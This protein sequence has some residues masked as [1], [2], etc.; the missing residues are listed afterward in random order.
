MSDDRSRAATVAAEALAA[1]REPDWR[2]LLETSRGEDRELLNEL[3][4]ISSIAAFHDRL[5]HSAEPVA[6]TAAAADEGESLGTWGPL[7]LREEIGRG[8]FGSVYRAWDPRIER[9]VALK[10]I[11]SHDAAVQHASL[12]IEEGRKLAR[13]RHPNV[14]TIF[15]AASVGGRTGLE[16]ELVEGIRLDDLVR[17]RGP[18][19]AEEAA[20]IGR[21]VCRGLAAIHRAGLVHR[22]V[23]AQNVMRESGGRIVLMD[24][25]ASAHGAS[26]Q[27]ATTVQGVTGTPMYAALE[28]LNGERASP[29]TDFYSLG[30]LL[31]FLVSGTYPFAA[32]QLA[33][34]RIAHANRARRRLREL[35]PD[36]P[37]GFVNVV[38]RATSSD[39][40]QR[41]QTAADFELALTAT[42]E[43]PGPVP[44]PASGGARARM[45]F[46]AT[47]LGIAA[48]LLV[49]WIA[50]TSD[51][52][53]AE[54]VERFSIDLPEELTPPTAPGSAPLAISPDGS[55]LAYA[56]LVRRVGSQIY[57]RPVGS[58]RSTLVEGTGDSGQPF[59][60]P[61]ARFVGYHRTFAP[62]GRMMISPTGP[63]AAPT[64][65]TEWPRPAGATWLNDGNIVYSSSGDLWKI[66][67]TGGTPE[68]LT[69]V[70]VNAGEMAIRPHGLPG[71]EILFTLRGRSDQH[72]VALLT[73][74]GVITPLVDGRNA[75]HIAPDVLL[76][77]RGNMMMAA[78]LDLARRRLAG[79]E[80]Q[81]SVTSSEWFTAS[82]TGVVIEATPGNLPPSQPPPRLVWVDRTTGAETPLGLPN[83]ENFLPGSLILSPDG[84]RLAVVVR[85]SIGAAVDGDEA[86]RVWIA[87]L[88]RRTVQPLTEAAARV[89]GWTRD[90]REVFYVNDRGQLA[91]R[92]G[93]GG[94]PERVVG[95]PGHGPFDGCRRS[96]PTPDG[97]ALVLSCAGR[98][99]VLPLE[100]T[101]G[102]ATGR[103]QPWRDNNGFNEGAPLL[104]PD[105]R[106]LFFQ[107]NRDGRQNLFV[108]P[109]QGGGPSI[110]LLQRRSHAPFWRNGELIVVSEGVPTAVPVR[111]SPTLQIGEPRPLL[112]PFQYVIGAGTPGF[113]VS[114]DGRR[115]L[116]LSGAPRH[117]QLAL[118]RLN[119]TLHWDDEVR[120]AASEA[121]AAGR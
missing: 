101:T 15:G 111:T 37:H 56:V 95:E 52:G 81:V 119:V 107:S 32:T 92:A 9:E 10:L 94:S 66:A 61:D 65:V 98:I 31:F 76:F 114:P 60:S 25:G 73:R 19:G 120:A 29:S 48:L 43:A 103:M 18:L 85:G 26:A 54:H 87:D 62:A 88:G 46:A 44:D 79:R 21:A 24:L 4:R 40:R 33:D 20:L 51:A 90:S 89:L 17:E 50:R 49:G 12:V 109:F 86:G 93:D 6:G 97:T 67:A 39:P 78:R 116:V 72:R 13:V 115:F 41:F 55:T 69:Q 74:D 16:M 112:R 100:Q 14:V 2:Q 59:L 106:Y 64:F 53:H 105:G 80:K 30:V 84:A 110:P 34:L 1:G 23:K 57:V 108:A 3:E 58:L 5:H 121:A 27:G 63:A 117:A 8:A 99:H 118:T 75:R 102:A 82:A 113:H 7:V 83:E 36:L 22:D 42:L 47:S 77:F 71:G 45:V 11:A 68:R 96:E 104:S 91:R 35:R 70:D 28:V 38:E